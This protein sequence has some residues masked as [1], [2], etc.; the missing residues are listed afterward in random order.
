MRRLSLNARWFTRKQ[1]YAYLEAFRRFMPGMEKAVILSGGAKLG[2][3]DTRHLT[4]EYTLTGDDVL[5]ARKREDSIARGAWPCE[6]HKELN[7][8]AE[9]LYI[10]DGEYYSIPLR[11]LAV[12]DI[13]NLWSAGRTISADPVAFASIRVMG[14]GFATGHAAGVVA[15]FTKGKRPE[16]TLVQE[17]LLKQNARF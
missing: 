12:K 8:A 9:Y 16:Y 5:S 2:I 17:E 15:A 10:P 14:I 6:M 1:E 11:C 3:R 7:E 4:G 13:D